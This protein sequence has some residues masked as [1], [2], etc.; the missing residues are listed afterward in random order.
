MKI[1]KF[2]GVLVKDV[3]GVKNVKKVLDFIVEKDL[4]VVVFVMGKMI[5]VLE[6]VVNYY[7]NNNILEVEV[8]ISEV[9]NYYFYILKELFLNFLYDIYGKVLKWFGGMCLFIENNKF[10]NYVFVYD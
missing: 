8:S 2:G 1:F 3:E 10:K 4:V 9:Y 7:F 5:N 6:E